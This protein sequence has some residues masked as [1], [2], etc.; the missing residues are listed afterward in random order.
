MKSIAISLITALFLL[1]CNPPS[2]SQAKSAGTS[3]QVKTSTGSQQEKAIS[4]IKLTAKVNGKDWV[5]TGSY[6]GF[7]YYAKGLKLM[8]S[9]NRPY[10][11]LAFKAANAPDNRTLT[12]NSKDFTGV[13]SALPNI[14]VMFTGHESGIASKSELQGFQNN[15]NSLKDK[16]NFVLAVTKWEMLGEDKA[17]MS[18][19][20]AGKLKGIMGSPDVEIID[21]KFEDIEVKV[22][23][24]KY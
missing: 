23:N 17:I 9:E 24:E 13:I 19:T 8:N 4:N 20:L 2:N 14:E 15:S 3:S 10:L 1:A 6:M 11:Q 18:G 21:G 16:N 5:A 22:Y 7:L 12:I